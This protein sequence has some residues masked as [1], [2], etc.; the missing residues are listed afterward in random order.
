[1]Q[2]Y[3]AYVK[4]IYCG[5]APIVLYAVFL[6]FGGLI[7]INE[8]QFFFLKKK[9]SQLGKLTWR[10]NSTQAIFVDLGPMSHLISR[11]CLG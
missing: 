11:Q 10:I 9:K 4:L 5:F 2:F 3:T 7:S 6:I 1:M 8:L